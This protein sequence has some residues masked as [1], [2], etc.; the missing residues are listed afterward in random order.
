[1]SSKLI[2]LLYTVDDRDLLQ[3]EINTIKDSLYKSGDKSVEAVLKNQVRV[4]TS[5]VIYSDIKDLQNK[6]NFAAYIKQLESDL[7]ALPILAI[8]IGFVPTMAIVMRLHQKVLDLCGKVHLLD[9]SYDPEI[10]G[11]A[12][13]IKDGKFF[14]GT[15]N[16][17]FEE[18]FGEFTKA[19][20]RE[21]EFL[22]GRYK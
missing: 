5:Q 21:G 19:V 18:K 9:I 2:E 20:P 11:G 1:M 15:T 14:D 7:A 13:I 6:E 16:A 3:N 10:I 22:I 12:E 17:M 8:R 4:T